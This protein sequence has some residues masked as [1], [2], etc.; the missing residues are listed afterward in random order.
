MRRAGSG[1]ALESINRHS[2]LRSGLDFR[3][4]GKEV[5]GGGLGMAVAG[6]VAPVMGTQVWLHYFY[7]T[8][9]FLL[10]FGGG[11]GCCVACR[12]LVP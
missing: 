11:G 7:L 6:L 8:R 10:L 12:I 9:M 1:P 2:L 5:R 4:S 3:G